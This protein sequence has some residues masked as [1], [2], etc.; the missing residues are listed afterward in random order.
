ATLQNSRRSTTATAPAARRPCETTLAPA[1]AGSPAS[2]G[3]GPEFSAPTAGLLPRAPAPAGKLRSCSRSQNSRK[4]LP[5][6]E[7]LPRLFPAA[8][9]VRKHEPAGLWRDGSHSWDRRQRRAEDQALPPRSL[10]TLLRRRRGDKM[11]P[12]NRCAT[13]APCRSWRGREHSRGYRDRAVQVLRSCPPK[14]CRGS[15]APVHE[16]AA[17]VVTPEIGCAATRRQE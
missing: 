15:P 17:A 14:D 3:A 16:C 8:P 5:P 7:T 10:P 12:Q 9:F 11:R 2:A 6:A 4:S 13:Q 1:A